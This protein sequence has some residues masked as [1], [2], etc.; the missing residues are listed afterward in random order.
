MCVEGC[1]ANLFNFDVPL[2]IRHCIFSNKGSVLSIHE[3]KALADIPWANGEFEYMLHLLS[4]AHRGGSYYEA[5]QLWTRKLRD[6]A[7][8]HSKWRVFYRARRAR[9]AKEAAEKK[10]AKEAAKKAALIE[11]KKA[12]QAASQIVAQEALQEASKMPTQT[13]KETIEDTDEEVAL[14]G[15]SSRRGSS[16]S[17]ARTSPFQLPEPEKL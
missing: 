12:S 3:R 1:C 5:Q 14:G 11:S 15:S 2:D 7:E 10:A 17:T 4:K 8:S 6:F 13:P 9:L 16:G